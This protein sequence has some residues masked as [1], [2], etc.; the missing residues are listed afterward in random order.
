MGSYTLSNRV[1]LLCF[2][3][4]CSLSVLVFRS[5]QDELYCASPCGGHT[6]FFSLKVGTFLKKHHQYTELTQLFSFNRL[7][8]L[9]W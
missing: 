1:F 8:L 6:R 7:A 5:V 3:L 4:L 9:A 2:S